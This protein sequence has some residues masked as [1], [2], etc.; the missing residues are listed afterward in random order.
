MGDQHLL[1]VYSLLMGDPHL[2]LLLPSV[3]WQS[4]RNHP[5]FGRSW[6]TD[7]SPA[8]SP[9][10]P[11]RWRLV[12]CPCTIGRSATLGP[13]PRME[14]LLNSGK[15]A[16][17]WNKHEDIGHASANSLLFHRISR[18]DHNFTRHRTVIR[19][20]AGWVHEL[21]IYTFGPNLRT[22]NVTIIGC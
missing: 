18:M 22:A 6:P 5:I 17:Y 3:K 7:E 21:Y 19:A 20:C 16:K 2:W 10:N 8:C 15:N 13:G 12:L 1:M 11:G 14:V 4:W 9:H